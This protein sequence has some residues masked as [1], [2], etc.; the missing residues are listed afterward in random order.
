[1][2]L[3]KNSRGLEMIFRKHRKGRIEAIKCGNEIVQRRAA[4][5]SLVL[6]FDDLTRRGDITIGYSSFARWVQKIDAG[7]LTPVG[8]AALISSDAASGAPF[9]KLTDGT[10]QASPNPSDNNK[11][12]APRHGIAGLER[13]API[14]TCLLYTS[15]AADE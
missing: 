13:S 12:R 3:N 2:E 6:I 11:R 7:E 1:M 8:R 10:Q 15:D 14:N 4:G 9:E 5:E